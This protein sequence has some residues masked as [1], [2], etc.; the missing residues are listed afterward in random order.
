MRPWRPQMAEGPKQTGIKDKPANENGR[1]TE[2]SWRDTDLRVPAKARVPPVIRA[3]A[4]ERAKISQ[5][6]KS[7]SA[8][9]QT[10][11][12]VRIYRRVESARQS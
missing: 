7:V 11:A 5:D 1:L 6:R 4:K 10:R 3:K 12:A 8:G 2:K 9:L